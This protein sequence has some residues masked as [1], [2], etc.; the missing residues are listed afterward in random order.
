MLSTTTPLLDPPLRGRERELA[1]VGTVLETTRPGGTALITVDAPPGYGKTRILLASMD[2][3]ERH[4]Y[5]VAGPAATHRLPGGSVLIVLDECQNLGPG[6]DRGLLTRHDAHHDRVVWLTARRTD[7]GRDRCG[8]LLSDPRCRHERLSLEPLAPA[9]ARQLA[10]DVLGLPPGPAVARLVERAGGH[11]RLLVDLLLGM[12]EEGTVRTDGTEAEL[13]G[14]R[15][16]ERVLAW[17]RTTLAQYSR[18]CRQFLSVAAVLGAEV[19]Y[20]ELSTVLGRPLS[21]LLPVMEE[22]CATGV[23]R[24]APDRLAFHSGLARQAVQDAVPG[25]LKRVL[26]QEITLLRAAGGVS[27]GPHHPAG[28]RPPGTGGAPRP[29]TAAERGPGLRDAAH[30]YKKNT[31]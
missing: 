4:G 25:A 5:A 23:V 18:E 31:S 17:V 16:P 3:A 13:V 2:L 11:P 1:R 7:T 12:R 8:A 19:E 14:S 15:L 6:A 24:H 30:Q 9:A 28:A 20:A 21:A 26:Y 27:P 10:A 22:A 29:G